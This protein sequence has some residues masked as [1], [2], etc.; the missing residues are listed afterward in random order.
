M[1]TKWL[2]PRNAPND[3]G[4][5]LALV[6]ITC[7]CGKGGITV[8]AA[9][10]ISGQWVLA[11]MEHS[12]EILGYVQYDQPHEAELTRMLRRAGVDRKGNFLPA[13]QDN[14]NS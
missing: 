12:C 7:P 14:D 1:A 8:C 3:G 11:G 9:G 6:I 4:E 13:K 2:D 10:R 5:M